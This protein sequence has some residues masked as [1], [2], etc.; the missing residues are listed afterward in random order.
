M[1]TG[2]SYGN[3]IMSCMKVVPLYSLVEDM[4]NIGYGGNL[5]EIRTANVPN[6]TR[7]LPLQERDRSWNMA[8]EGGAA[9]SV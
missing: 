8:K 1:D 7:T 5:G 6:N 4:E 2:T 9:Y 3:E